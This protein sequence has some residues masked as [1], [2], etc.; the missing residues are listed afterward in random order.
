MATNGKK[1]AGSG[2]DAPAQ[3]PLF[4]RQCLQEL[5][6]NQAEFPIKVEGTHTLPYASTV[7]ALEG[8]RALI[9]KLIRPLPHE[10]AAGALFEMVFSAGDRRYQG[11]ITFQQ[12]DAYLTY[13]FSPPPALTLCDR[14]RHPRYPFRP[15]EKVDVLAQDTAVPGHG[16]AGPLVNLSMG[17]LAFRVDR[18]VKLDSGMRIPVAKAFFDHGKT[19]PLLRI[20]NLPRF[21]RVDAR[22]SII[23]VEENSGE[24]LLGVEFGEL[25]PETGAMLSQVIEIR[26][27]SFRTTAPAG[28]GEARA[29]GSRSRPAEPPPAPPPPMDAAAPVLR[30][31]QRRSRDLY[32]LGDSNGGLLEPL[33]EAGYLRIAQL[34]SAAELGRRPRAQAARS[35][36]LLVVLRAGAE[37][38]QEIRAAQQDL[39]DWRELPTVFLSAE[40]DPVAGLAEE[41]SWRL[42]SLSSMEAGGLLE[43]LDQ[44]AGIG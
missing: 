42:L 19:L 2:G 1:D 5:Q 36:V 10:L 12:R 24:V 28:G 39:L 9:L 22:G 32:L 14:R 8:E 17:G 21:P 25:G 15:R 33:R 16:L 6:A 30:T 40:P 23:H 13:R 20:R 26:E 41:P 43:A 4:I 29:E 31:L 18:I 11:L 44:L 3:D 37:A 7:V 38:L 35:S 34:P 27:K